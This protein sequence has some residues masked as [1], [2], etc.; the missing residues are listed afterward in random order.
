[1]NG[2]AE[3][4][5]SLLPPKTDPKKPSAKRHEY[6]KRVL[7]VLKELHPDLYDGKSGAV[8][9][10]D[11]A[12]TLLDTLQKNS[13]GHIF[14]H[15]ISFL[16]RGLEHGSSDLGWDVVIP[17][18]PVVIPREKPF[19]THD[20]FTVLPDV[21]AIEK[22][23]LRHL[24]E[25]PPDTHL[26]RVG[27]LLLSAIL[28]GGLVRKKW[29]IAW[30]EALPTAKHETPVL[31]L[32][33]ILK[34]EHAEKERRSNGK[35]KKPKKDDETAKTKADHSGVKEAWDI[36]Q[37]WLADPM[38]KA[39][40][41]RWVSEFPLDLDT[42]AVNPVIALRNYLDE[43]LP[44]NYKK[45]SNSAVIKLLKACATTLGL[46]VPPFLRAY[47]EGS[48]K[49]VS[50]PSSAWFRLLT[51]KIIQLPDQ[52]TTY[53]DKPLPVG[54][55]LLLSK[56]VKPASMARQEE[57]LKDA[58]TCILPSGTNW[59]RSETE[60]RES[61]L[62]FYEL[63]K[64][65]LCVTLSCLM[66]WCTDLLTNYNQK[67]LMRGRSKSK[68]RASS[69][70]NYLSAV[71]KRLIAVTGNM[72]ILE[73][74]SDELRDIY[75]EAI[76]SCPT[77]KSK[78][79]AGDRMYAFH[80]FLMIRLG[81]P[82]VDFSDLTSSKGPSELSVD[83]NLISFHNFDLIK[84]VLCPD[85]RKIS[86]IRKIQLLMAII[87][88]RCGLRRMEVIKLRLVD[89]QGIAEP[90]LLI[91]NNRYAYVKS[92]E[93]IRRL[94]LSILLE[95]DELQLLL[96]WREKRVL[97]DGD[98]IP[99]ALLF[100]D[101]L[102]PT[103]RLDANELFTPILQAVRQVTGDYSLVFRHFRHSFATWILIRLLKNF[104]DDTRQRFH[105][106]QHHLFAPDACEK[107]RTALLGNNLL[108]R[109]ALYA[110]AQ[111][112]GH[113]GPEVT[114]MHYVH[115]CDWLL[116]VEISMGVN[117][118]EIDAATI[119][120]V[121]GLPQHQLYYDKSSRNIESWQMSLVIDRLPVPDKF[122]PDY[123]MIK[124]PTKPVPEAATSH[125]DA[126]RPMWQ[127]VF[128]VIRER[129]I[130]HYTFS[131]L[132]KR[133]GFDESE[134]KIWC[135]NL[136]LLANLKTS[137]GKLRHITKGTLSNCEEK[138]R[139]FHFPQSIRLQEDRIMAEPILTHY[140]ASRGK[141]RQKIIQGALYFCKHFTAAKS[142][143]RCQA[144]I[145]VKEY[146]SFL[147]LLQ[148]LPQHIHISRVQSR[149]AK[150]FPSDEKQQLALKF[151]LPE[152]SITVLD[153]TVAATYKKGF[154]K[155]QV[156]NSKPDPHGAMKANYGFR[157]AMYLI[158]IMAGLG[159][160]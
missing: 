41:I 52:T 69:V 140:E 54:A 65:E 138:N 128:A 115:L 77:A 87:G 129:Q 76:E 159:E 6:C 24:K 149:S 125:P 63:C 16:I 2:P 135:S 71:G 101:K 14:K 43:L 37:R 98:K 153:H 142:A 3:F 68:L 116:T 119:M 49:S 99:N 8:L 154:F 4:W 44:Q 29:L 150:R 136:E 42:S 124:S 50:L 47:A 114:L 26:K 40:I 131:A 57:I 27:Q 34:T 86:R 94:P 38:T 46:K 59:K 56:Q 32:D 75:S 107:L 39:L 156:M 82:Q 90:E 88:F 158:A 25:S 31:W 152:S 81:A 134:I 92:N 113:A 28:Y 155:I 84:K 67:N 12:Q 97:E 148:I 111:L 80:Q 105:F 62:N 64:D 100:C 110:T 51:G 122:K 13:P 9:T 133:S 45:T 106:L 85:F 123:V 1:M 17:D 21:Y 121:T 146:L 96:T 5:L 139:Q 130:G 61:L 112:C 20:R 73:L 36:K 53:D 103:T 83:A 15:R 109:Q 78:N 132:S 120:A 143:V 91:R 35:T 70:R 95:A 55:P 117:Q 74:E 11:Q 157:F 141:K 147:Q 48:L 7:E 102:Q 151:G 23:F 145:D 58:L 108:G 19:F 160:G 93:S 30:V 22:A 18:P 144:I 137:K 72:N 118:P 79:Y 33:M 127:R 60:A 104:P 66:L 89:L 126:G 10:A